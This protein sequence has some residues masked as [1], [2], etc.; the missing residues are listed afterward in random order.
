MKVS[1]I[2]KLKVN[3][4]Q[5]TL[6]WEISYLLNNL[7]NCA[8]EQR[9][10]AY[11][12]QKISISVYSQKKELPEIKELL[13][14]YQLPFGRLLHETLFTLDRAYQ[15]FFARIKKNNKGNKGFPRFRSPGKFFT[16]P[17][18]KQFIKIKNNCFIYKFGEKAKQKPLQL[19]MNE[20]FPDNYGMVYLCHNKKGFYL[21]VSYKREKKSLV[22][23]DEIMAI[24]LGVK[25]TTT[26]ASTTGK[27]FFSGS[28]SKNQRGFSKISD[29][30]RSIRDKK[31]K[32]SRRWKYY[33]KKLNNIYT[34]KKNK[35]KDFLHKLSYKLANKFVER[36]IVCGD[37]KIKSMV[38][39]RNQ[40]LNRSVQNN[41]MMYD[42]IQ[43]L[44]YKSVLYGKELKLIN[45]AYTS[46]TCSHCGNI[47]SMS[48]SQRSYKCSCC[49]F[50]EDR[51]YNSAINILKRFIAQFGLS[52][53]MI[54]NH[55]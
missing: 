19:K 33:N 7:Y 6:L 16:M 48:L 42:F 31:V 18:E 2:I 1:K 23:N 24:D 39:E 53:K 37:L 47:K 34:L 55:A 5:E 43:K 45:E 26:I 8:L 54:E 49:G 38:Q 10:Q 27:V 3:K 46:K 15:G 36:T 51:D 35:A 50:V 44:K 4:E 11:K 20:T 21:S 29:K 28:I 22:N 13:P 14:E 12:K 40:G 41:S 25:R 52:I 17:I 9:I 30:I 32:Y